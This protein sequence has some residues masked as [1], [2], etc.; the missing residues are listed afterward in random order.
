MEPRRTH[1]LHDLVN[2]DRAGNDRVRAA[3]VQARDGGATGRVEAR[4]EARQS[5]HAIATHLVAVQT[6]E[7]VL[8]PAQVNLREVSDRAACPDECFAFAQPRHAGFAQRFADVLPQ[9]ADLAVLRGVVREKPI[10]Q[11]ERTEG[12]RPRV[13]RSAVAEADDLQ[14]AAADVHAEAVVDV[15]AVRGADE[16]EARLAIAVHDLHGDTEPLPDQLREDAA[17]LRLTHREGPDGADLLG[18]LS[19]SECDEVAHRVQGGLEGLVCE[20]TVMVQGARE[21]EGGAQFVDDLERAALGDL[22]YDDAPGVGPDVDAKHPRTVI[23]EARHR[24]V[25]ARH[26]SVD[27]DGQGVL[28]SRRAEDNALKQFDLSKSR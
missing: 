8:L 6:R 25:I 1:E 27:V 19:A 17:V 21:A 11:A 13:V 22:Q 12:E 4:E 3:A 16:A 15:E 10:R 2:G 23:A 14:G 20:A 26:R 24:K 9:G 28:A 5:F 18:A 7:G